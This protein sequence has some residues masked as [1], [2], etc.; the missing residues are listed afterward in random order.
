M[1][2]WGRGIDQ[3]IWP[4]YG[5]SVRTSA[6]ELC[7]AYDGEALK[8]HR[9]DVRDLAPALLG[10][11]Q[12]FEEAN[13]VVNGDRAAVSVRVKAQKAGSFEIDLD[14]FQ[15]LAKQVEGFL[16][17]AHVTAAANLAGILGFASGT[18][19]GLFK[20][21]KWLRNRK[22]RLLAGSR[23]G[24]V[25]VEIDGDRIEVTEDVI[26]LSEDIAVRRAIKKMLEP[27]T[28]E[29]IDTFEVREGAIPVEVIKRDE[30]AFFEIPPQAT[31]AADILPDREWIQAFSL[32]TITFKEDN[33]WRLSDGSTTIG[34][35]M[36]DADF[37]RRVDARTESFAKGDVLVCEM[38]A[39][40]V[41]RADGLHTE[42]EIKKVL[43]H[44]HHRP[45]LKLFED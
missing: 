42:Y 20:L 25:V 22:A 13:R 45:Q 12:L 2:S 32:V 17:G 39:S 7:V 18:V 43:Q 38:K 4:L 26:K 21:L 33:K 19:L 11:G 29:G 37:L 36:G 31:D 41:H 6:A 44:R 28:R 40:Q 9:I 34:A 23:P 10:I 5:E 1:P 14:V 16:I 24:T 3:P 30:L 15:T 27:L 8:D 35:S